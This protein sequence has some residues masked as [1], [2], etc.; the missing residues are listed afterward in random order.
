MISQL[1]LDFITKVTIYVHTF[2]LSSD[3][4]QRNTTLKNF[5]LFE[6]LINYNYKQL[7]LKARVSVMKPENEP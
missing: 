4:T 6:Q 3:V 7:K 1:N 5:D 2:E